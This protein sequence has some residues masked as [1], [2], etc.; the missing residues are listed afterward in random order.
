MELTGD[1]LAEFY[2][3]KSSQVEDMA[4]HEG[5]LLCSVAQDS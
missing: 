5:L 1:S 3:N 2:V 4:S